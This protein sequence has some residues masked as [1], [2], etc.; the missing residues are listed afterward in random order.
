MGEYILAAVV[1]G[2]IWGC[3]LIA[4]LLLIKAGRGE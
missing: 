4:V 2:G 3:V 1:S